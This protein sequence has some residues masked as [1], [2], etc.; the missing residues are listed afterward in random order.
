MKFAPVASI[1][2][3]QV[4]FDLQK[5][6]NPDIEGIEYQQGSL[7]GYTLR[8]ALLEHWGRECAYCGTKDI[9]LQIEHIHPKSKGET[10]QFNNLALACECCNQKKGNQSIE[11]FLSDDAMRLKQ[12]LAHQKKSLSDAA[13]VN[14]TRNKIVK[15]LEDV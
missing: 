1:A 14:A 5:S 4:K 15:V 10:N 3:E 11:E 13:A 2:V 8:E 7:A 9:P 6:E 12:L